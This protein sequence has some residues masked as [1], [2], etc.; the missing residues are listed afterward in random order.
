MCREKKSLIGKNPRYGGHVH[1][2]NFEYSNREMLYY[3]DMTI[4]LRNENP[5]LYYA[6]KEKISFGASIGKEYPFPQICQSAPTACQTDFACWEES[7][8]L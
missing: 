6:V 4:V 2:E 5:S 3:G 8:T 1:G 7:Q